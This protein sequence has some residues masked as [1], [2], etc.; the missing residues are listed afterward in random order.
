M[1][2]QNFDL[3]YHIL[4]FHKKCYTTTGSKATMTTATMVTSTT[5]PLTT[6]AMIEMQTPTQ[7]LEI[8]TQHTTTTKTPTLTTVTVSPGEAPLLVFSPGLQ[9]QPIIKECGVKP[10]NIKNQGL[11]PKTFGIGLLVLSTDREH[12]VTLS[13]QGE[14]PNKL[15]TI[16]FQPNLL[17]PLKIKE[18]ILTKPGKV[19][20]TLQYKKARIIRMNNAPLTKLVQEKPFTKLVQHKKP[21][22]RVINNQGFRILAKL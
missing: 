22:T 3:Q 4:I 18:K 11:Q 15:D 7:M 17:A 5:T 19:T 2:I 21:L 8:P 16:G 10:H 1:E 9:P 14:K 12:A 6:I 13:V 20:K